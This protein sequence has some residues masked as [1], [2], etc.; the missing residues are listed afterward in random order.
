MVDS[1]KSEI[2]KALNYQEDSKKRKYEEVKTP[3]STAKP[4]GKLTAPIYKSTNSHITSM[5]QFR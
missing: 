3:I 4:P 1:L 5:D 2:K